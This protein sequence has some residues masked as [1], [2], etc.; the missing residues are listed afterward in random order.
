MSNSFLVCLLVAYLLFPIIGLIEMQTNRPGSSAQPTSTSGAGVGA[1]PDRRAVYYR[2]GRQLFRVGLLVP[3]CAFLSVIPLMGMVGM[4]LFVLY[5]KIGLLD[6]SLFPGDKAWSAAILF[7][8]IGPVGLLLG[9]AVRNLLTLF[10]SVPD[11]M[12]ITG[13]LTVWLIAMPL[14]FRN[15]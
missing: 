3:V 8:V 9:L 4:V 10:I 7:S 1:A 11:W 6:I 15:N 13:V 2:Q 5:A 14:V 12:V